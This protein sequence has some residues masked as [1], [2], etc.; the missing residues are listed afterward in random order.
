MMQPGRVRSRRTE[1]RRHDPS[2][3]D[4]ALDIIELLA[5]RPAGLTV[6]EIVGRIRRPAAEV[7]RT[8]AIMQHRQWLRA[9]AH[10]GGFTLGDRLVDLATSRAPAR[11]R[12]TD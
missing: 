12:D 8:I 7:V 4:Q 3:L 2:A 9:D 1:R 10:R 6:P 5:S 11:A